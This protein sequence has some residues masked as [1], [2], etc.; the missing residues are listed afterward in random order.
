MIGSCSLSSN[1]KTSWVVEVSSSVGS[2]CCPVVIDN[3]KA[4]RLVEAGRSRTRGTRS[5][6]KSAA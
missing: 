2:S 1:V 4:S 5:P 3:G 6:D